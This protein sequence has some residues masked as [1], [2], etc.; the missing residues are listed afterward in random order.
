MVEAV[1]AQAPRPR[2]NKDEISSSHNDTQQS[3]PNT[4]ASSASE[5]LSEFECDELPHYDA[6]RTVEETITRLY[7]LSA[8]IR[9][10]GSQYRDLRAEKIL[11]TWRKA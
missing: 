8:A 11:R 7:R 10:S 6:A 5:L 4:P 2:S 9:H 3:R 1:P